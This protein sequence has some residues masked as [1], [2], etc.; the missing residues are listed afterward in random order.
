MGSWTH[1]FVDGNGC[2]TSCGVGTCVWVRPEAV[3]GP[4]GAGMPLH[5]TTE[6]WVA[7]TA[8]GQGGV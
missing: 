2:N 6:C 1:L 4:G 3:T 8:T 7:G 5:G